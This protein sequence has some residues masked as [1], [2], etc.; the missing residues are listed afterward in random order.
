MRKCKS[1]MLIAI[2]F[3]FYSC[4][5]NDENVFLLQ[6][7]NIENELK[8]NNE[9]NICLTETPL[10]TPKYSNSELII[11][12]EQNV[13]DDQK[14]DLRSSFDVI[15]FEI[16]ENCDG[17]IEKWTFG[18]NNIIDLEHKKASIKGTDNDDEAT[19][20][21]ILNVDNEFS[22]TLENEA[23]I[24]LSVSNTDYTSKI[25]NNH[26]VTIAVLDSG[27]ASDF[28][29]F[30]DP[31]L[32]NAYESSSNY[33]SGSGWN[34][35]SNVDDCFDDYNLRHGTK[36]SYMITRK[37][38][39]LEIPH[40]ILPIKISQSNGSASYFRILCGTKFASD[41]A[42]IVQISLGWYSSEDS[43]INSIFV[44]LLDKNDQTLFVT[45]AGNNGTDNDD[46]LHYPSSYQ[47][48]NLLA[49]AAINEEKTQIADFSNYGLESVDFY[50]PGENVPFYNSTT[51]SG[52]SFAA[53][54]VSAIAAKFLYEDSSLDI[55][56]LIGELELYGK[57][58]TETDGKDVKHHLLID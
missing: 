57:P 47:H 19:A 35:V 7:K 31:F 30:I 3:I 11:Q 24:G 12:Y 17:T 20:E 16:C 13:T 28:V 55:E 45:S 49:I 41:K 5:N 54:Y 58:I 39:E 1:L 9:C 32:F 23:L 33:P 8:N 10:N 40:Q 2:F 18:F 51:I 21:G 14:Q 37:L 42:A 52:T 6:E 48:D 53:P 50:A 27:V 26:G 56:R 36:V 44:D 46:I 22:F 43:P 38:S 15:N 34:F 4:V 29:G 25:I